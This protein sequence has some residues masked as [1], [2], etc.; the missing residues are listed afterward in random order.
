MERTAELWLHLERDRQ[1]LHDEKWKRYHSV[2]KKAK[3]IEGK[4]K[5]ISELTKSLFEITDE[6]KRTEKINKQLIKDKKKAEDVALNWLQKLCTV[7]ETNQRMRDTLEDERSSITKTDTETSDNHSTRLIR[8]K[9][10]VIR[11]GGVRWWPIWIV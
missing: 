11:Y 8:C 6:I 4:E 5:E 7:K 1:K 2:H 3:E 10:E 9:A